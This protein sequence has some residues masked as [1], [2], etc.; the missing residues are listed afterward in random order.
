M[1]PTTAPPTN[2]SSARMVK[3][4]PRM[5]TMGPRGLWLEV[6]TPSVSVFTAAISSSSAW[7]RVR[8]TSP[9]RRCLLSLRRIVQIE[10]VADEGTR[11]RGVHHDSSGLRF[12]QQG[13]AHLQRGREPG[14]PVHD[15]VAVDDVAQARGQGARRG[16]EARYAAVGDGLHRVVLAHAIEHAPL[17]EHLPGDHRHRPQVGPAVDDAALEL[18]G[19]E[20]GRLALHHARAGGVHA[21]RGLGDAEVEQLDHAL[22]VHHQVV[23]AQVAV[24]ELA[25]VADRRLVHGV[26][27]LAGLAQQIEHHAGGHEQPLAVARAA[28][29][30]GR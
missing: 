7:E 26:G 4:P 6:G 24:H 12:A 8:I 27:A 11:L 2:S 15:Q 9:G 18:L 23:R 20:V 1:A 21:E 10:H 22:F 25:V 30:P 5:A 16:G 28:R 3:T 19:G 13:L 17:R 29:A 14:V